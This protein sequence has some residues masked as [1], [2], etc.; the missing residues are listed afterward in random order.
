MEARA[1]RAENF[2][3]P[4]PTSSPGSERSVLG[5]ARGF[6][7]V[8]RMV[9]NLADPKGSWIVHELKTNWARANQILAADLDGDGKPDLVAGTEGILSEVRWWHNERKR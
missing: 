3:G 4:A 9:W 6:S 5:H 7:K 8:R 2:Q 1:A